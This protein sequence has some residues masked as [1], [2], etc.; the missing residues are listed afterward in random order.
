MFYYK[1]IQQLFNFE[2]FIAVY[3]KIYNCK[4]VVIPHQIIETI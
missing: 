2:H 4:T 1:K 3:Y